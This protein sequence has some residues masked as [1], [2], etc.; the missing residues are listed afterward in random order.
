MPETPAVA[1]FIVE[2]QP[3][4]LARGIKSLEAARGD[5]IKTLVH[6]LMGTFGTY[7]LDDAVSAMAALNTLVNSD[8][9]APQDVEGERA[10]AVQALLKVQATREA[11][12]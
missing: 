4:V 12:G 6:R 11:G 3:S 1:A 9:P 7:Q 2:R 10:A 5:Q 8:S